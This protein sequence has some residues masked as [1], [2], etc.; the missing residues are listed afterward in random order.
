MT[1]T[2]LSQGQTGSS[3]GRLPPNEALEQ[4]Y[5]SWQL[6]YRCWGGSHRLEPLEGEPTNISHRENCQRDSQAL[7]E[8][9]NQWLRAEAFRPIREMLLRFLNPQDG[10]R[11][12]VQS[13]S[14]DLQRLPWQNWEILANFPHLTLVMVPGRY[15]S[16]PLHRTQAPQA[17][18]RIL[19]VLSPDAHM[20]L[21]GDLAALKDLPR[22]DLHLIQAPTQQLLTDS[23][24][25]QPWDIFFFAGHSRGQASQGEVVL[26]AQRWTPIGLMRY[27]LQRSARQGLRLAIFNSCD[28]L[29]IAQEFVQHK[30]PFIITMR[31]AVPDPVAQSFLRYFLLAY[32]TGEALEVAFEQARQRLEA[33]EADYPC[34]TWLPVLMCNPS[35]P[36]PTWPLPPS[37]EDSIGLQDSPQPSRDAAQEAIASGSVLPKRGQGLWTVLVVGLMILAIRTLGSLQSLELWTLDQLMRRRLPETGD[38]RLVIVEVDEAAVQQARAEQGSITET[39]LLQLVQTLHRYQPRVV[40]L[41]IYRDNPLQSPELTQFFADHTEFIGVCKSPDPQVDVFGVAPPQGFPHHRIGFS[42]FLE[43]E[44]G[45]VR[46]QLLFMTPELSQICATPWALSSQVV[47]H[48]LLKMGIQPRFSPRDRTGRFMLGGRSFTPLRSHS[49]GYQGIDARGHQILLSYRALDDLKAI[50]PR[51]TLKQ[52]IAEQIPPQL[53]RDRLV[54]V[55]V[56]AQTSSDFWE[57]PY[58]APEHHRIPGV[59]VQAH[60]AS[61]LLS[62]TLDDRPLLRPLPLWL[63]GLWILGWGSLTLW[64]PR[65]PIPAG[66]GIG[67]I[68]GGLILISYGSLLGGLWVPLAP[69]AIAVLTVATVSRLGFSLG[70]SGRRGS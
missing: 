56:T 44:D 3:Q 26:A 65:R 53:F 70:P 41:D 54:L 5:Q 36:A 66:M 39:D 11:I 37:P 40:G 7:Q 23:L 45:V 67:I 22:A 6:S 25:A 28:G 64:R 29:A 2:D 35:C 16:L 18:V 51:V 46:R 50:A 63:D 14:V 55:G 62:A 42:D 49:G 60:M 34:A 61:Q 12:L 48:Y 32:A 30:I 52:V 1:W 27:A 9:F 33:L 8:A 24:W 58:G 47:L 21:Q 43:D 4:I 17:Q 68:L 20:D 31:E 57:T 59:F 38:P 15:E 19:A 10:G 69:A 13:S